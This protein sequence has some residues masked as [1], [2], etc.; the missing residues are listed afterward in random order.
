MKRQ[1]SALVAAAVYLGSIS[2]IAARASYT[3]PWD[4]ASDAAAERS[5]ARL[6][7]KRALEIRTS[8]LTILQRE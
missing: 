6:G 7:T 4:A 3:G 8:I 1:L 2:N 5:V